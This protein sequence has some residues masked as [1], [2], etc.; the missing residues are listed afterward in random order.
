LELNQTNI[1]EHLLT[2][3]RVLFKGLEF[4][5]WIHGNT[6]ID[7]VVTECDEMEQQVPVVIDQGTELIVKPKL[8]NLP[9]LDQPVQNTVEHSKNI[10]FKSV[11]VISDNVPDSCRKVFVNKKFAAM[12]GYGNGDLVQ[13]VH[14]LR[15]RINL[16]QQQKMQSMMQAM[17]EFEEKKEKVCSANNIQLFSEL[18]MQ[19]WKYQTK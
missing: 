18:F 8:R 7:V 10:G 1:E 3:I 11:K 4:P 5:L 12:Y 9:Q 16:S 6:C 19:E 15:I 2:Q 13:I 17:K 14:I